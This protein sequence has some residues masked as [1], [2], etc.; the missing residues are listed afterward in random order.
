[1]CCGG[2]PL[3]LSGN[4]YMGDRLL[5]K[6]AAPHTWAAAQPSAGKPARHSFFFG[7][8]FNA[9]LATRISVVIAHCSLQLVRILVNF[10]NR[11][12]RMAGLIFVLVEN[13]EV[14]LAT[15]EMKAANRLAIIV[16]Q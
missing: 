2:W 13:S 1:M 11:R 16:V 15:I 14:F 9:V 10:I 3:E 12:N 6:N 5:S 8:D 7:L 4:R